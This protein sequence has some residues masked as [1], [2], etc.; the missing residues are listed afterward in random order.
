MTHGGEP[1]ALREWREH[2]TVIVPCFLG[3]ML[4]TAHAHAIGVMIRPLEQE[5]GW[6]RAQIS[7]GFMFISIMSLVC[8]P[9]IGSAVDRW[10]PRRIATFGIPFYCVMLASLSLATS[11]ILTWWGLWFLVAVGSMMILPVVWI[12]VI[13]GYFFRSRGLAMAV[14]LSGTGMGAAVWPIITN[15]LIDGV[16]WRMA[17]VGLA[18]A[19]VLICLPITLLFFREAKNPRHGHAA[20]S[21]SGEAEEPALS[22]R[23]Q[24]K[25]P[26]F[27]KLA[28][29]S[30]IFA[31]ASCALTNN[32]VPVLIGE[33]LD[34]ARAAAT[35]GLLGIGSITGRIA[36][37]FLLDR[38]DG[39]KVAAISV[40][41]PIVPTTILLA[42]DQSQLWAGLACL[43]MGLSV[44]AELDCCAYLAARHFG[45]RNFGA[46]FGTIN[47][48]LLFGAGIAPLSANYVFDI[49]RSYDLVLIAL[50][51]LFAITAVLFFFMG[52]YRHLDPDTG[53]PLALQ[54]AE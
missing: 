4:I 36:G 5:F 44:G 14:A 54:P 43:V 39:N 24:M 13:N 2:W 6:P 29:A 23:G 42:T 22:A 27:Y 47:G 48:M 49:T 45:T 26:R 10:G 30:I 51:P 37:G 35:A 28:A 41:L 53:R 11:N 31:L 20:R 3:I 17:Y 38:F 52:S 8:G 50:I 16:G 46:L 33:G 21:E 9:L 12:A 34:P 15:T 7:A 25:S 18:I 1:G 40:L 32:M 19:C